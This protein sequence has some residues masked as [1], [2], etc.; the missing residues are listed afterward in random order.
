MRIQRT[1]SEWAREA[2]TH[3][4]PRETKLTRTKTCTAAALPECSSVREREIERKREEGGR[5]GEEGKREG[6]RE[7]R[8]SERE[9]EEREK[10]KQKKTRRKKTKIK[11]RGG[12]DCAH[13]R[14]MKRAQAEREREGGKKERGKSEGEKKEDRVKCLFL[15]LALTAPT[16]ANALEHYKSFS[17][18]LAWHLFRCHRSQKHAREPL[19]ASLFSLPLSLSLS[20]TVAPELEDSASL[21]PS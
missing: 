21:L 8:E 12:S 9:R 6:G 19:S 14:K 5:G 15:H 10:E 4:T 11:K 7:E 3:L 16:S 18:C 1:Q 17:S 20:C 2:Q 13:V